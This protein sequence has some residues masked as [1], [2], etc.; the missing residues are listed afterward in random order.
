MTNMQEL[1]DLRERAAREPLF[2][3]DGEAAPETQKTARTLGA[4]GFALNDWW[5]LTPPWW[6]CP[7][8]KRRKSEIAR[9]NQRGAMMGELHAHHDHISDYVV[10]RFHEVSGARETIE[11][12]EE[13]ERFMHRAKLLV[14]AFDET[15]IC[16]DC[17]NADAQAK[18]I[19]KTHRDFSFSP[20]EIEKF[21]VIIPNQKHTIDD[22]KAYSV[23]EE[24]KPSFEA[25]LRMIE[26]IVDLAANNKHWFQHSK[27]GYE[28]PEA[29]KLRA[30][31]IIKAAGYND[32]VFGLGAYVKG[33]RSTYKP[34]QDVS[35]W[36]KRRPKPPRVPTPSQIEH[37]AKVTH[38]GHWSSTTDDWIC[39][40]C[41]RTKKELVK[42]SKTHPW[43]IEI[44]GGWFYD[45]NEEKVIV[46]CCGDCN[47]ACLALAKEAGVNRTSVSIEDIRDIVIPT[48]HAQHSFR[49]D[50]TVG[51]VIDRIRSR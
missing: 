35:A 20:Q 46:S 47:H 13:A 29:I 36:R 50:D 7:T 26:Q 21:I 39:P 16:A 33:A 27:P 43:A 5:V 1:E 49:D 18:K 34:A 40:G 48:P 44:P 45:P 4:K 51:A 25:Q 14:S 10:R 32:P 8:C 12:N 17:N 28:H 6:M 41:G 9:L 42:P 19:V 11:A 3:L 37:V 31:A 23:W 24:R 2:D 15:V 38:I 22:S 30:Q